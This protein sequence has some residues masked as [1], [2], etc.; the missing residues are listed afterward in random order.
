MRSIRTIYYAIL[1]AFSV[2]GAIVIRSASPF[3]LFKLLANTAG[4]VLAIA[5]IQILL[6][7]R[8]FLPPALQPA[9]WRQAALVACSAFYAFF[10]FWVL[11]DLFFAGS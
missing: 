6:V 9:W 3:Q 4:I 2:W 1:I 8:Q 10:A 11:R 5:G 7:N